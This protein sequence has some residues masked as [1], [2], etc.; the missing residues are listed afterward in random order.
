[1]K[2]NFNN[3]LI[4]IFWG[5][6]TL[7]K[8]LIT[9]F[10]L[11]L[12]S[13]SANA[14]IHFEKYPAVK[15][16]TY[17]NWESKENDITK[18]VNSRISIPY[19]YANKDSITIQLTSHTEKWSENS[20]IQIFRNSAQTQL[21]LEDIAF[22]PVALD[23]LC[24]ADFNSDGLKDLKIITSYMGNG[25]A[26]LNVRVIYLFQQADQSFKKISFNDKMSV[27]RAERDFDRDGNFEI[28]TMD[29]ISY[30]NHNYWL[31]NLFNYKNAELVSVNSKHYYPIMI[32]F[33][34]RDNY[35]ITKK[36][37]KKKL[38]SFALP[39][40]NDYIAK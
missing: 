8:T 6:K 40:P 33:L 37:S 1:M 28:I 18:E 36:I 7:M 12:L 32:Q 35:E 27:N 23:T 22:Y 2:L 17:S 30:E 24:V 4:T 16:Q 21:L 31:Y 9:T 25:T 10:L 5:T 26:S 15:Y 34:Y 20:K 29:L 3:I 19:F 13:W 11:S 38:K 14:Q 39:L